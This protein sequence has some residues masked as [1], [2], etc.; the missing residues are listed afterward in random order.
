MNSAIAVSIV[1]VI[2]NTKSNP[3]P[4]D[5]RALCWRTQFIAWPG[6]CC[7]MTGHTN[8]QFGHSVLDGGH[9]VGS[10][11]RVRAVRAQGL[12]NILKF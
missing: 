10:F 8:L 5:A 11:A 9:A 3:L 1:T 4:M 6:V 7:P 12:A 2:P